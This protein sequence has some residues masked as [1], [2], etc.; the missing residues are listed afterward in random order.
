MFKLFWF[1]WILGLKFDPVFTCFTILMFKR[2][3]LLFQAATTVLKEL[4]VHQAILRLPAA[5]SPDSRWCRWRRR[6]L[7]RP[8]R[9]KRATSNCEQIRF[10]KLFYLMSYQTVSIN[11]KFFSGLPDWQFFSFVFEIKFCLKTLFHL[12]VR[13]PKKNCLDFW[14][15]ISRGDLTVQTFINILL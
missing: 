13:R 3:V 6:N 8:H 9:P 10:C 2:P 12:I 7:E 4:R 1:I 11:L 5:E 15:I 14:K